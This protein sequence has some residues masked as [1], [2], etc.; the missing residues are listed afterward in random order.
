MWNLWK[1]KCEMISPLCPYCGQRLV[2]HLNLLTWHEYFQIKRS[3]IKH[4]S[5]NPQTQIKKTTK[6]TGENK[7]FTFIP[8]SRLLFSLCCQLK[9]YGFLPQLL[10]TEVTAKW[11]KSQ[12]FQWKLR[13]LKNEQQSPSS[14]SPTG[15]SLPG[16]HLPFSSQ[17]RAIL[18]NYTELQFW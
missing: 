10:L 6:T 11:W 2:L 5:I 12:K 3:L 18:I 15:P 8:T 17:S 14:F 9:V 7:T 4:W 1:W 16:L 13:F